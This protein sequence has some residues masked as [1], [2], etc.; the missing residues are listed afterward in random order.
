MLVVIPRNSGAVHAAAGGLGVELDFS[1]AN[2][3]CRLMVRLDDG[4]EGRKELTA[5]ID[6][7][8]CTVTAAVLKP[9]AKSADRSVLLARTVTPRADAAGWAKALAIS[10]CA[11]PN[12]W[13]S[14]I[15]ARTGAAAARPVI[16][17]QRA[18]ADGINN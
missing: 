16:S 8:T 12:R 9:S 18:L 3:V 15:D 7:A 2:G 6:V 17:R 5:M 4:V 1:D 10:S 14:G 13:L 11:L